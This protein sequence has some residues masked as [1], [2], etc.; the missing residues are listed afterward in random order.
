MRWAIRHQLFCCD[1]RFRPDRQR[2]SDGSALDRVTA[3]KIGS[4]LHLRQRNGQPG[5]RRPG[6][7]LDGGPGR[8]MEQ[9][10]GCAAEPKTHFDL[11]AV[12]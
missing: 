9:L 3:Q 12:S 10:G 6:P 2:Q 7:A 11:L 8:P 5:R 1:H 4:T